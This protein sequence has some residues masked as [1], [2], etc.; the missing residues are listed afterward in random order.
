M[1]EIE[2]ESKALLKSEL[3][4]KKKNY[5]SIKTH[6]ISFEKSERLKYLKFNDKKQKTIVKI[7][8]MYF[9][10]QMKLA[11]DSQTKL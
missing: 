2:F 6:L 9:R 10:N 3:R 7:E 8:R 1:S 4:Q 11:I 5:A